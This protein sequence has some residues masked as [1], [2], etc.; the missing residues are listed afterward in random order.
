MYLLTRKIILFTKNISY[1]VKKK[2]ARFDA[3][4]IKKAINKKIIISVRKIQKFGTFIGIC[5]DSL[6]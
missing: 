5:C 2:T 1:R 4:V 6:V 3:N